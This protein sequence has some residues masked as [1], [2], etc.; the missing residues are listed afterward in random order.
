[1]TAESKYFWVFALEASELSYDKWSDYDTKG[2]GTPPIRTSSDPGTAEL[3]FVG[4]RAK[5]EDIAHPA[6]LEP[7][8][9]GIYMI[10]S[11]I[12]SEQDANDYVDVPGHDGYELFRD[13]SCKNAVLYEMKDG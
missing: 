10:T 1:M 9:C 11:P 6:D 12:M 4:V 5:H 8:R 2:K 7:P 3:A 13:D